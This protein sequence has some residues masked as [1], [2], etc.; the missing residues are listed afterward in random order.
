MLNYL[1]G[2]IFDCLR[3]DKKESEADGGNNGASC[4]KA[5]IGACVLYKKNFFCSAV[6]PS[7]R[8]DLYSGSHIFAYAFG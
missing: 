2:K 1:A 7:D 3:P 6:Y 5:G 8:D 4:G